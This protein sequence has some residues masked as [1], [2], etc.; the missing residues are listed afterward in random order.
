MGKVTGTIA[1][2]VALA[3]TGGAVAQAYDRSVY[4]PETR[5]RV[6]YDAAFRVTADGKDDVYGLKV[7]IKDRK[8][9]LTEI[10]ECASDAPDDEHCEFYSIADKAER[11]TRWKRTKRG[12]VGTLDMG[13][14]DGG[15]DRAYC[16][17]LRLNQYHLSY[18]LVMQSKDQEDFKFV[19]LTV[20]IYCVRY[21]DTV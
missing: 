21:A 5:M 15:V 1:L 4:F 10:I 7:F 2:G 20:P 3:F 16:D 14:Y 6:A 13:I 12:W 19:S 11:G 9:R 8:H 18:D 17:D